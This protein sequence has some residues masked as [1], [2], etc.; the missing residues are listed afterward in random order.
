MSNIVNKKEDNSIEV[1]AVTFDFLLE[2]HNIQ[3]IYLLSIDLE[4]HEMKV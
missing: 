4:G 1:D 3:E 2:K